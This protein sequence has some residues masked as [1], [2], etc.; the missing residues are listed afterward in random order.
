MTGNLFGGEGGMIRFAHA[1]PA[2][3]F[4]FK[5]LASCDKKQNAHPNG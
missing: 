4:G 3:S 1:A 2:P 5:P